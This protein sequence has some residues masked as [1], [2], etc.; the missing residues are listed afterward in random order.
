MRLIVHRYKNDVH[1]EFPF[2]RIIA[3]NGDGKT[4]YDLAKDGVPNMIGECA[5]CS[6]FLQFVGLS[7]NGFLQADYRRS[8]VATK[9]KVVYVKDTVLDVRRAAGFLDIALTLNHFLYTGED[10]VEGLYVF[11]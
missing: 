10:P 2:P 7:L 5:V 6:M 3:M 4:S 8:S 11:S 1:S 9:L